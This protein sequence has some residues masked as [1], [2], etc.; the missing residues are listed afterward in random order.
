LNCR[1]NAKSENASNSSAVMVRRVSSP[2]R[3]RETQNREMYQ[4]R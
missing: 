1:V 4:V 3:P 2:I